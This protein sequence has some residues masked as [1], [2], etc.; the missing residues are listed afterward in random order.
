MGRLPSLSTLSV[1][2][3]VWCRHITHRN[4]VVVCRRWTTAHTK[5]VSYPLGLQYKYRLMLNIQIKR[6][7]YYGPT[8]VSYSIILYF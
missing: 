7:Q 1:P 3:A 2:H 6:L 8:K 5:A 4:R